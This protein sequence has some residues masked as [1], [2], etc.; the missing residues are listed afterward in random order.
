MGFK[1][2]DGSAFTN[3]DT[4]KQHERSSAAKKPERAVPRM[5]EQPEEPEEGAME[6]DGAAMA[7]A[8]SGA[9]D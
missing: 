6:S 2:S 7:P 4:M 8:W 9:H 5:P 1:S 3:R